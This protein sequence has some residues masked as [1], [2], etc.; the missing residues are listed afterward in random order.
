MGM[1]RGNRRKILNGIFSFKS[2]FIFKDGG[3]FASEQTL[4]SRGN[5]RGKILFQLDSSGTGSV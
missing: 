5:E 2:G 4:R 3:R 1:V